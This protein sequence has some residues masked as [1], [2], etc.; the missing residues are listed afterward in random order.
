MRIEVASAVK[1]GLPELFA[2]FRMFIW[3]VLFFL[4]LANCHETFS[5]EMVIK[6]LESGHL[7]S[8]FRFVHTLLQEKDGE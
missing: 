6:P 7:M 4:K 3:V 1:K 2:T 5:E 8:H